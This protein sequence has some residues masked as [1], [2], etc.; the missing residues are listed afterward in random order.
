STRKFSWSELLDRSTAVDW[1]PSDHPPMPAAVKGGRSAVFACGFCHLP[2]GLGRTENADLAGMPFQYLQQQAREMKSGARKLV[3]PHF[4]PGEHM[5]TTISEASDSDI[6]AALKY[7]S[8]LKYTKHLR[9]IEVS[10]I[11]HAKADGF[12][13]TF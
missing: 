5:F 1:Y 2:E 9:V 7:F 11:P 10:A 12:V 13:Y 4:I 6:D 8:A 3:D